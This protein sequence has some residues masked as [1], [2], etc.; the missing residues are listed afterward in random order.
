MN[1]FSSDYEEYDRIIVYPNELEEAFT[2]FM[3]F[4][5]T[6]PLYRSE[7]LRSQDKFTE[8]PVGYFK[9]SVV[10]YQL[11]EKGPE[12]ILSN[13]PPSLSDPIE[14]I[15]RVYVIKVMDTLILC[16]PLSKHTFAGWPTTNR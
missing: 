5:Q 14:I 11:P 7:G 15:V 2:G 13:I 9:G 10:A 12:P 4:L 3:D 1:K 8:Q 16:I 6:F